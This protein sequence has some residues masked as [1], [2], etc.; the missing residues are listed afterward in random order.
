M[1]KIGQKSVRNGHHNDT[2][3][4]TTTDTTG[5]HVFRPV[6]FLLKR[7]AFKAGFSTKNVTFD[8][9]TDTTVDTTTVAR[10]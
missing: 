5:L 2:T 3:I 6:T 10:S 1:S 7:P 9:T 8:T 4:D